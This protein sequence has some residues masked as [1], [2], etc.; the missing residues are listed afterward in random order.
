MTGANDTKPKSNPNQFPRNWTSKSN[1]QL[2]RGR[3]RHTCI[4]V[5][6]AHSQGSPVKIVFVL[7]CQNDIRLNSSNQFIILFSSN[8]EVTVS[9][10]SLRMNEK[11]IYFSE[12]IIK[13]PVNKIENHEGE[14]KN[15]SAYTINYRN[16]FCWKINVQAFRSL[17]KEFPFCFNFIL[18]LTSTDLA[19]FSIFVGCICF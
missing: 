2:F 4:K 13:S 12:K 8:F 14:W 3:L 1:K 9:S 18:S 10:R 17:S 19:I 15:N 11:R 16:I 7:Y 5:T 6:L